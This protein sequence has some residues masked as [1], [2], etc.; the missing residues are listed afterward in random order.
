MSNVFI[1]YSSQDI[2]FARY[3]KCLLE[4]KDLQVWIDE[5]RLTTSKRWWPTIERAIETSAAVIVVMS[6]DSRQSDWVERE[7]L[8]AEKLRKPIFPVLLNGDEW[9]RL[10]N[11]QYADM[12]KGLKAKLPRTFVNGLKAVCLPI[13]GELPTR[14]GMSLLVSRV[15]RTR[16]I[17]RRGGLG[18]SNRIAAQFTLGA[19]LGMTLIM[20]LLA[21]VVIGALGRLSLSSANDNLSTSSRQTMTP[22][23]TLGATVVT[24]TPKP[25]P[26]LRLVYDT[27]AALLIN[28]SGTRLDVSQ[29]VFEQVRDDGSTRRWLAA[30]WDRVD[31]LVSPEEMSAGGCYQLVKYSGTQ[32]T[33]RR[34]VCTPFLGWFRSALA[35]RYFWLADEPG[36]TFSVRLLNGT[37]PLAVCQIDTGE[38]A[39]YLPN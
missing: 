33:P 26:N 31:M 8:Y 24:A 23:T 36:A 7:V 22:A 6:L 30:D 32:I 2:E 13:M 9:P 14:P 5:S 28:E 27:D 29:L 20:V 34:S 35:S 19:T 12:R 15:H 39:F 1:S 18:R 21:L 17:V 38:C 4:A 10:A 3:L 16:T 25:E 11:I 37:E